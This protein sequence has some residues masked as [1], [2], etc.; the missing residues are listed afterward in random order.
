M[1]DCA[2]RT[3]DDRPIVVGVD[4][5]AS[6]R[7]AATWAAD[8]AAICATPLH[9]LTVGPTSLALVEFV[10]C[11]VVVTGP[12][13]GGRPDPRTARATWR[14]R[15]ARAEEVRSRPL[16]GPRSTR[17]DCRMIHR[18]DTLLNRCSANP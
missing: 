18:G 4:G 1:T 9:L 14:S 6:A 3:V 16:P 17:H 11:P 8:L 5:S 7:D 13:A 2:D 15:P 10:P 12:E